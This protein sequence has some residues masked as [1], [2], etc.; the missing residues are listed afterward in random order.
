MSLR[1]VALTFQAGL[2]SITLE[3]MASIVSFE[4]DRFGWW[5]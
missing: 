3:T 5:R 4:Y 2:L 1:S